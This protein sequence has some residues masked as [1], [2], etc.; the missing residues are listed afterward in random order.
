MF[1]SDI[2]ETNIINKPKDTKK[3]YLSSEKKRNDL[4]ET[5]TYAMLNLKSKELNQKNLNNIEIKNV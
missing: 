4:K 3:N 1:N 5:K 2:H